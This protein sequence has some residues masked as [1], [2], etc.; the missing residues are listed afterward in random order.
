[1]L[2]DLLVPLVTVASY[3]AGKTNSNPLSDRA[4]SVLDKLCHVKR[5]SYGYTLLLCVFT[6]L[7]YLC[8]QCPSE[9]NSNHVHDVLEEL[10]S[11][12]Q[13]GFKITFCILL[14]LLLLGRKSGSHFVNSSMF[15]VSRSFFACNNYVLSFPID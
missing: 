11:L 5:V 4:A 8:L 7:S 10:L 6:T 14:V 15:I 1:M 3:V 2:Q 13:K 12:L 9:V